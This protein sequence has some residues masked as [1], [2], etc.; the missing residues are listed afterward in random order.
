MPLVPREWSKYIKI[1]S[2]LSYFIAVYQNPKTAERIFYN[3]VFRLIE[4]IF[5][6]TLRYTKFIYPKLKSYIL[7]D[8]L[9]SV[10]YNI[11]VVEKLY[12]PWE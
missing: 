8:F 5:L 1:A 3:D 7:L 9:F 4:N 10:F 6:E 12:Y 2:F 11:N